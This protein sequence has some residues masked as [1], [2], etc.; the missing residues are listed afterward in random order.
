MK[1][2]KLKKFRTQIFSRHPSHNGLRQSIKLL[3]FR[4]V[5]RFGSTTTSNPRL[6]RI[7]INSIKSVKISSNKLIMK[8]MFDSS[9]VQHAK[10]WTIKNDN[11]LKYANK[12]DSTEENIDLSDLNYPIVA[13]CIYG[14]RGNGNYLLKTQ[15]E[16]ES[17]MRTKTLSRYIFEKF[18][19]YSREYRLH[20]SKNGCF[21]TCR[22]VLKND[23]PQNERW[24]RHDDICNWIL[25]ENPLFDKPVNW[26]DIVSDC[27]KALNKIGADILA[28]DVKVQSAR[29][30]N[31]NRRE[32]PK[33]ILLESNSAPSHGEITREKYLEE[34]P[35]LLIQKYE[36]S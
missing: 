35:K 16:L 28:F 34:I 26:D 23:A 24:R 4:S 21:Y 10:W 15:E 1:T 12:S 27:V 36:K 25:E 29:K 6:K 30:P 17:W 20:I 31:G 8:K 11:G 9:E 5:V 32:S 18:Y 19:S 3:P 7:E 2:K 22:K 14:S 13:K 33:Y